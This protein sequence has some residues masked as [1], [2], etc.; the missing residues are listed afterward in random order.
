[1]SEQQR[2]RFAQMLFTACIA[3]TM[4]VSLPY[5][6]DR[7]GKDSNPSQ[8]WLLLADLVR[9]Y[10][11]VPIGIARSEADSKPDAPKQRR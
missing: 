2:V 1:M 5:A 9:R 8:A 3:D 11:P 7:Y 10:K 6:W 4:G